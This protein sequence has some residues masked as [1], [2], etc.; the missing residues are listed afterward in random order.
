MKSKNLLGLTRE[1]LADYI[2]SLDEQ[3]FRGK[4]L[5]RQIYRRKEFDVTRMTD[6]AKSLRVR[7]EGE[8]SVYLPG[9]EQLSSS[10]DGTV[11]FL[12]RL[13][14]GQH[15]ESVYIPE[16][17]RET[18]C[19]SS[20]VGCD[21]GCTF[22]MTAQMGFRRNL[23][24]GEIVGQVLAVIKE[25]YLRDNGF[26]VVFMGMGEPLYNYRNVMKAFRLMI[27]PDGM[28]LSY[29]RITVSTAGVVPI[30]EKMSGEERLPNLAIS[31]NAVT[32][33]VRGRIM[34]INR[35][36]DLTKL[37]EACRTFPLEPRRRITF[38]YVLL[39]GE[40]DSIDDAQRLAILLKGI[41][42]KINVI[43]YNPNPGLPHKRPDSRTVEHFCETLSQN[44]IAAYVRKTRGRDI[45]A[46]C[47]QL[48]V[49][50]KV[51]SG[52]SQ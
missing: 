52:A 7:L 6:L 39:K 34:P 1:E 12:F 38:E 28:N 31:L 47:G 44:G 9:I 16:E 33:E 35:K 3:A 25:G 29:R 43:P 14:D 49:P 11:K 30:L 45:A 26:N 51:A 2:A 40:N 24:P 4:Q 17:N 20:Q 48:A 42:N 37:L 10:S 8:A 32:D 18:L 41:P 13:E 27:D 36:W 23:Q 46:A 5:Y 22:C 15:I 50:A 21:V 19:I